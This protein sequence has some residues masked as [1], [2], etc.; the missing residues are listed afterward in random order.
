MKGDPPPILIVEDD[1]TGRDLL[2]RILTADGYEGVPA[3]NA[4]EARQRLAERE[5]GAV[6]IDVRM[7]GESGIELLRHV[8]GRH[9]DVAAMMVTALDDPELMTTAFETGA[10]A[11]VVKPYRVNELLINLSNTLHRRQREIQNRSHVR[12]LEVQVL[13]RTKLL[14]EAVDPLRDVTLTEADLVIDRLS[15]AL[16]LVGDETGAHLRRIG[17]YSALLAELSDLGGMP[18]GDVVLASALH[19][20]GKIGVPDAILQKP[21]PLSPEQRLVMQRHA[22]IGHKLLSGSSSALLDLGATIALSHHER[23]DGTGYPAGLAGED[24]PVEGRVTAI[25]DSFDALTSNRPYRE[26]LGVEEA[27]EI[28]CGGRETRFDP[29]LLDVFLGSMDQ[30]LD[31]R[32]CFQDPPPSSG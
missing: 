27:A 13:D 1:P 12:E 25:A 11:Y 7:P 17:E 6:L 5:F 26:A 29:D 15:G 10:Y 24:I 4:Q 18:H 16:N 9:P 19:D 23:W 2:I 22:V 30:V 32:D 21:D 8:R 3:A 20:I 28:M 14:R 31:V